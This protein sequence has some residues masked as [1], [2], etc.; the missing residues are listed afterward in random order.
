MIRKVELVALFIA[1]T[2]FHLPICNPKLNLSFVIW[3]RSSLLSKTRVGVLPN[4]FLS[5]VFLGLLGEYQLFV[6]IQIIQHP[7][8][9]QFKIFNILILLKF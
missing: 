6:S 8:S 9:L 5:Q 2:K 3:F 1:I 4:V 7:I